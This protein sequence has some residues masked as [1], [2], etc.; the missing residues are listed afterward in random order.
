MTKTVTHIDC[1][2]EWESED[3]FSS[4]RP[5]LWLSF[6]KMNKPKCIE[7]GM[8]MG[9][10]PI[11]L[12]HKKHNIVSVENNGD[13]LV[14]F[15]QGYRPIKVNN[16]S[17]LVKDGHIVYSNGDF[18]VNW[19][20]DVDVIHKEP[21]LIFVDQ[22]PASERKVLLEKLKDSDNVFVCHDVELGADYVYGMKD[23]LSTFKYRINYEPT[24]NPHTAIVSNN[25][26][27]CEWL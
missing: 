6:E 25:I 23:I 22:A 2:K 14:K 11:L 9:S 21:K 20:L 3:D 1:P 8:G 18:I 10:T 16:H 13:W 5:A 27:V 7:F 4:H 17:A 26:N 12:K 24:G 15:T 19:L